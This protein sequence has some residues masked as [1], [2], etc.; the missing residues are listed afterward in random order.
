MLSTRIIYFFD[1]RIFFHC[2]HGD[3]SEDCDVILHWTPNGLLL[4]REPIRN[5]K[6]LVEKYSSRVLTKQ[7]DAFRAM[8]GMMRRISENQQWHIVEGMPMVAIEHVMLFRHTF[9]PLSRRPEFPSYSWLGW[10]GEL[11]FMEGFFFFEAWINWFVRHPPT[12]EILPIER[13]SVP[14]QE[15]SQVKGKW[16]S[17]YVATYR[18]PDFGVLPRPSRQTDRGFPSE[19]LAKPHASPTFSL[20]C[21]S[22]LA[23]F[24]ELTRIDYVKGLA[25]IR[26]PGKGTIGIVT[27]DSFEEYPPARHAEFILLCKT[28]PADYD[29][30]EMGLKGDLDSKEVY[31]IMLI[32]WTD[33]VAER[34]GIGFVDAVECRNSMAPGPVWKDIILG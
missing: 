30:D 34:R 26:R 18:K 19:R 11:N 24:F 1:D 12:G 28:T 33:G 14:L 21:F 10:K 20:L 13:P 29:L 9:Q 32:E 7:A 27:L 23:V 22:T 16:A 15:Q 17:D 3:L 2:G 5:Y 8:S 25:R 31:M 6:E 4:M